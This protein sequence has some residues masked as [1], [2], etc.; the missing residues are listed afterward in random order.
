M[1]EIII[2]AEVPVNPLLLSFCR[3]ISYITYA[4]LLLY[5][6]LAEHTDDVSL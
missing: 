2:K 1:V 5:H 6:Y 4:G 3:I